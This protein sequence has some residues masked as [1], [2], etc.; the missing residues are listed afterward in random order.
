MPAD[1]DKLRPT[2]PPSPQQQ[3]ESHQ[4]QHQQQQQQQVGEEQ[5]LPNSNIKWGTFVE[6]GAA[7]SF[8]SSLYCLLSL[9]QQQHKERFERGKGGA[10][11]QVRERQKQKDLGKTITWLDLRSLNIPRDSVHSSF[12]VRFLYLS[13]YLHIYLPINLSISF[14]LSTPLYPSIYL[15]TYLAPFGV[16]R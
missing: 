4:K 11:R 14:C 9:Q 6:A 10:S 7:M 3:Q 13:I 16:R 2:L 8:L 12:L 5:Q 15:P 1:F